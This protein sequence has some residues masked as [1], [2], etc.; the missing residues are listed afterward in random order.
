MLALA[1]TTAI[2][3][4]EVDMTEQVFWAALCVYFEARG[5]S[6]E[7]QKAVAHVLINRAQER[8]KTVKEIVFQPYQFSWANNG[9]RPPIEDYEAFA[10]C[11]SAVMAAHYD[12]LRGQTLNGANHYHAD[13][14]DIYPSWSRAMDKVAHIGRHI[15]YKG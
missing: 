12:R 1:L 5:E 10:R 13:W 14:M 9:K 6:L 7:G 4:S 15:F 8:G 2:I 3:A 11:C